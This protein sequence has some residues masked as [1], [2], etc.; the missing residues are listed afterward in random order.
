MNHFNWRI[1]TCLV[2]VALFS[3]FFKT[4]TI[5]FSLPLHFDDFVYVLDAIQYERGD[6]FMPPKKN[7]GW[8]LFISP[9]VSL[10]NSNNFIDYSNLVRTLNLGIS[11]FTIL[12]MYFLSRKFFNEKFAIIST[13][14]FAFEPHL[15]YLS[16]QGL[17]EPIFILS[18]IVAFYF[19]LNKNTKLA[20][21]AFIAGGICW[22]IRLEGFY[23]FFILSIIFFINYRKST[24]SLRNYLICVSIFLLVVSPMFV[25]RNAQYGN[26]F[27]VWYETTLFA[28]D[29]GTLL[30]SPSNSSALDYVQKNDPISFLD[31][32]IVNGFTNLI[33]TL[34]KISYPY[35]FIILPFG[36]LF[37]LRPVDQNKDYV[38]SNWVV[39]L[40][41]S[42]VLVIPFS[43]I[44]ERRFLFPLFPFLILFATI[45]IQRITEYGLSTFTFSEQNKNY[46]LLI[47]IALVILL[48]GIFTIGIGGVGYG[49]PDVFLEQEKIAFTKSMINKLDGRILGGNDATEY[50]KYVQ[51]S[52]NTDKFKN[53]KS[54]RGKDPYPDTY[55]PGSLSQINVYGDSIESLIKNGEKKGLKY[56]AISENGSYFFSFFTDIFNS[57]SEYPYLKKIMDSE[58][59]DYQKIKIKVYEINYKK[60][61]EINDF[62]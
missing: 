11:T 34:S 7:P 58:A 44:E 42:A 1:F 51:I 29:Y 12:P 23:V 5:D 10:V 31:R 55:V 37:S 15:N 45:P 4:Y 30:T 40:I 38:K 61:H 62:S 46:F 21:L 24:N 28:D 39:I 6:F 17:S 49:K 47:I 50:I 53:Y 41:T 13:I 26:P 59:M 27:Y 33:I 3:L 54:P 22:W 32:F 19:I 35:L 16:G 43:T 20:Y 25:Q 56:I 52:D 18:F 2:V 60:F 9:F 14:L 36:I 8:P 48:G 57:E